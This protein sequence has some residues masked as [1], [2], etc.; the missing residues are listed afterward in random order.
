[1][2]NITQHI[3]LSKL[4]NRVF[5]W[6]VNYRHKELYF[7]CNRVPGSAADNWKVW[8]EFNIICVLQMPPWQE[9]FV[10]TG[11]QCTMVDGHWVKAA[12]PWKCFGEGVAPGVTHK[13]TE[14]TRAWYKWKSLLQKELR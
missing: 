13:K 5:I 7:T 8:F 9:K 3:E 12:K 1:M 2:R 14:F 4:W 10:C 11:F 6:S